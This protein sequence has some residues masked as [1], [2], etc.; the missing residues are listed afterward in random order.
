MRRFYNFS[1][2]SAIK[3][4]IDLDTESVL[5]SDCLP[6]ISNYRQNLGVLRSANTTLYDISNQRMSNDQVANIVFFNEYGVNRALLSE[7]GFRIINQRYL[8]RKDINNETSEF[9]I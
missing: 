6:V 4:D 9:P 2:F 3:E 5:G 1:S 7:R 8:H